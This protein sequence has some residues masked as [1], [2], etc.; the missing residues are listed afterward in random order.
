MKRRW[1][2]RQEDKEGKTTM[3]SNVEH[4]PVE[5]P[6]QEPE[7]E[8]GK[9]P[10]APLGVF[11]RTAQDNE[12]KQRF[13]EELNDILKKDPAADKYC[14]LSMFEPDDSISTYELDR[15]YNA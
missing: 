5:N 7:K 4:A 15:I 12:I 2:V 10:R 8:P 11:L 6:S 1:G 13:I 14:L 3:N 9:E